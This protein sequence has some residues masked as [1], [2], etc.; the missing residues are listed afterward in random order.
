MQGQ[1]LST[2]QPRGAGAAGEVVR[3][4]CG[5]Q[6]QDI[7][8]AG[9]G[10]RVRSL[11]ATLAEVERARFVTKSAVWTW[12]MRGTL[13]LVATEDLDW[14]IAALG[15]A[16]IAG[17]R[18]RRQQLG[19][20]EENY[21]RGLRVARDFLAAHGPSTRVEFGNALTA[22]GLAAGYSVERHLLHRAAFEGIVCMGPDRG[23]T[24]TFVLLPDWL[25]R[26]LKPVAPE[27]ALREL[28]ARYLAAYAPATLA[29]LSA[30]SGLPV[31]MLRPAWEE[32]SKGCVDVLIGQ[33]RAWLPRE[34]VAELDN[35]PDPRYAVHLL[36]AFDTYLLGHRSR[37]LV[38]APDDEHRI[39]AGGI[40]NPA[41]LLDG[42]V[43]GAWR[44]N[45]QGKRVNVIVDAF[46]DLSP[47]A[48][49]G[50]TAEIADIERFLAPPQPA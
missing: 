4:V 8:A 34:R 28:I 16:A 46:A 40:I 5:L 7:F 19:L 15:P 12:A 20:D 38:L 18:T 13:H 39:R 1:S 21:T 41:L 30:W 33:Q 48:Q 11:N 42:W 37:A 36:P 26:P 32:A 3:R 35:S 14:L 25:G 2:M 10:V 44:T 6:A 17:T 29:D 31:T 9:L 43:I 49:D 24:P 47:E 45:R 23:A 50:V 27:I 22:A